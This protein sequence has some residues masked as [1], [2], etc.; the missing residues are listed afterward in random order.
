MKKSLWQLG[1]GLIF[2][3]LSVPFLSAQTTPQALIVNQSGKGFALSVSG[4][5]APLYVSS[6]DFPGVIRACRDLQTDIGRVTDAVP[7]LVT[8]KLPQAKQA[9]IAGT[10]GK[11]PAIDRLVKDGKIDE[12]GIAGQWE[13][14]RIQVVNKPFPGIEEALVITGS[15]KRGTIYGIY[16]LSGAIGVSPWHWWADVYVEHK[17]ALYILCDRFTQGPPVVKYRGIFL[18]DE[19]PALTNWVA[20]KY[21]MVEPGATPPIPAGVANY[22]REFYTRLFELILRLKGNYLWPAMW[23][24]AFNEDDPENPRLA[25]EYG[26][27]MGTTHQ[28]PM[29]RAQKEWDRRY[30][31]TL[32][33][34]NYA[35]HPQ[36]LQ[37]FW[38]EGIRRNKNY[39]SIITIGLRGAD[40]TE[41]APGGPE[42]NIT[43]LEGIVDVQRK[44]IAGEM[45]TVITAVPQLWCLYK[46]VQDYYNA[47]MRVPD[48]VTLL[49]AE[50]NWGNV[51]R[52]PT[53]EE[54]L[55]SGGAGIY[56]HFD[57]HGGPRSYQWI[58]TSPVSKIWDQMSLARQYG[59]DRIW[60]VNV[61]HFKGYEFPLE[62]FM[63]LAWYKD[64]LRNE[65]ILDYTRK[66]SEKQ[67]GKEYS[68][69]IADIIS[70][71]TR[72]NGRRKPELL[73]PDNYSLVNYR[74]AETVVND[75]RNITRQAEE[76]YGKLPP[77]R[78]D[79]FY[80]LVLFPTKA[81]ALVNE[82]YLTAGKNY[83]Y[84]KQKRAATNDMAAE[85]QRL[86]QADTSLM[87]YYNRIFSG[88]KWNHFMDQAHLGYVSWRDPPVN[89]LQAIRLKTLEIPGDAFM[90]IALEGSE[91]AWPGS[92]DEA[93]L[94]EFDIFSNQTRYF[95]I[96]NKGRVP[97]EFNVSAV[98][99]WIR[100]DSD[101]G[102]VEKEKRILVSNNRDLLPNGKSKGTLKVS[103]AG[104]EITITVH[105]FKPAE[106]TP[107]TLQGF[108]ESN[109]CV[110][111]EAEH[112]T[113]NIHAG[114][115][116]WIRIEEYGHTLSAMRA[117]S[118]AGIPPAGPG[119]DSPCLE[120]RMYLFTTGKLT[121]N[122]VFAPTLNF[123]PDRPL[124]YGISMDN[125]TPQIITLVPEN[126]N[127]QNRNADWERSVSDNMR[128]GYSEHE[129]TAAGYHTLKIW[130]IDPGV[131]LQKIVVNT[132]GVKDSYLGPPE[133]FYRPAET[134]A[135]ES[136]ALRLPRL[137]SDGMVLQRGIPLHIWGW[138]GAG[139]EVTVTFRDQTYRAT[140]G[141]NGKWTLSLPSQ[142]AGGP[143]DMIISAGNQITIRDIVIGD[144]WIC[145]GQSN[146]VLPME[147][148]KEKYANVIAASENRFI[149]HFFVA[150]QY[151]FNNTREDLPSG[152]WE[153][154]N[155]STVLRFTATGYFFAKTLYEKYRVPVGLIN[156]SMGGTP[157]EAW[158]S[159]EALKSF[160]EALEK[161]KPFKD[162]NYVQQLKK[163]ELEAVSAWYSFIGRNDPGIK[164]N[165][166]WQDTLYNASAWPTMHLPAFWSEVGLQQKQ[167]TV[168]F[169]KEVMVPENMTGQQARLWLG[170]IV[171]W[172]SVYV[173]GTC[174]GTT[175][176]QYPPRRYTVASGILKPG[177]NI[178]T[179]RVIN[180]GGRG[181]FIKDK[182]YFLSSGDQT[183][184]LT[185]EWQYM[186]GVETGPLPAST[187]VQYLP[188]G[189]F[190]AMIAPLLNYTIKGVIWYQGESNA[191]YAE[192]YYPLFS[193]LITDW[194]KQWKQGD[195]PFL[196]VQLPNS[197][198]E[199]KT[200]SE[201]NWAQLRHEQ[202]KALKVPNT[203]M[204]VTIDI[205]EWNDIH[206]LNKEDVGKRLALQAMK[207]A[208]G[209]KDVVSSGPVYQSMKVKGNKAILLF[210][211]TGGGLVARGGGELKYFA[212]AGTDYKF[213]WANARI[214]GNRVVVWH[215]DVLKPVAVRY[216][217]ADNPVS[218][219]L[220]NREGLPASP[221]TTVK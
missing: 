41:V 85:T 197:F 214:K 1:F 15:D 182:P 122:P 142:Q 86:F 55:R 121:I 151:D 161:V 201:S 92:Y 20:E 5:S 108:V 136:K 88:G 38:R 73:S 114:E 32:G 81:G 3:V 21:G 53:A 177:R 205:G 204:A 194:R 83:L 79:A 17:E 219:N 14:F 171:D 189:L 120:Y 183:I 44:I 170:R 220:Y 95:E 84:A 43:M 98:E 144:V 97:F 35:K 94:P 132:G 58:N 48:D 54:R 28:E 160:P 34:W 191:G 49:W 33:S 90:G 6:E 157:V 138:A 196:Y 37:D 166:Q 109:G 107:E 143:F 131:V 77:E 186:P 52:L 45:D 80:Q 115:N 180:T 102:I 185:G 199:K 155:P 218:A 47:G 40:D 162:D 67:F 39:E 104:Q 13:T 184:D 124:R 46:E 213:V 61:G 203:G 119:K 76:I 172:D 130:M 112:F 158:M 190:N 140:T 207:L 72:Y 178:I 19:Y 164:S 42:A 128:K 50:D 146:M 27:V 96:F 195:F 11:S 192:S 69:E 187:A 212:I 60:I 56:Y 71:Y 193:T 156:A 10:L 150:N 153:S 149:R 181:G 216:A 87:G 165:P 57:Y 152:R 169:R 159:A 89:S 18:N 110:S 113:R 93:A 139:E 66:W 8:G 2:P 24:N 22:N 137:I 134:S 147:R 62:Y 31:A 29:L 78:R 126:Y 82:L 100:I 4:K 217:W 116:Q 202:L 103:G 211:D 179:V 175:T 91:E 206:P 63:N 148:V 141:A 188:T 129:I 7:E 125:E 200:P 208:Y 26:I 25:D 209:E 198:E 133:S 59:A 16:E 23:N 75:F 123:L 127:A 163:K 101:K 145:S 135:A 154:A 111:I 105:A 68:G 221:F 51:R 106:I 117:T 9:V 174:V 167:G 74:E 118:P 70:K 176:Y 65:N 64:S 12:K 36:V 173:N 30:K 215:D 168:W 99:P 210:S